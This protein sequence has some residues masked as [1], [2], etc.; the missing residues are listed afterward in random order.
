MLISLHHRCDVA[1][2]PPTRYPGYRGVHRRITSATR[3]ITAPK[4]N[5]PRQDIAPLSQ[6][7]ATRHTLSATHYTQRLAQISR[8]PTTDAPRH[9]HRAADG[10]TSFFAI[11]PSTT[12][13]PGTGSVAPPGRICAKRAVRCVTHCRRVPSPFIKLVVLGSAALSTM[14]KEAWR[15]SWR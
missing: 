8:A 15:R 1:Y 6:A 13:A 5:L 10:L 4:N 3:G 9:P 2:D 14:G 12:T 7:A 11:Q